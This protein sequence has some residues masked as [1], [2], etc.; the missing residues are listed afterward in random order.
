M[1]SNSHDAYYKVAPTWHR[2][3]WSSL[4]SGHY[5]VSGTIAWADPRR[6]ISMVLLTT[7]FVRYSR[8][9]VLGSVSDLV[10]QL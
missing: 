10:S 6:G 9:G 7:K 2:Y 4:Y 1:L 8:E 5:G 3:G